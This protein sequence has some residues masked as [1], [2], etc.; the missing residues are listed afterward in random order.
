M[1]LLRKFNANTA[2]NAKDVESYGTPGQYF[3]FNGK[4]IKSW[5]SI[6]Y[7]SNNGEENI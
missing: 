6:D 2:G 1:I 4:G 3:V 7:L 5:Y